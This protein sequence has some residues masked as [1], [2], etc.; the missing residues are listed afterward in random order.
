[1]K[2]TSLF[3]AIIFNVILILIFFYKKTYI[4]FISFINIFIVCNILINSLVIF[5]KNYRSIIFFNYILVLFI[6][7]VFNGYLFYRDNISK[8]NT[9]FNPL[10]ETNINLIQALLA[11]KEREKGRNVWGYYTPSMAL[12]NSSDYI[13]PLSG[14][15]ESEILFCNEDYPVRY[16]SDKYGFNNKN[17]VYNLNN[18]VILLGDSYVN[19]ECVF[20]KNNI[21]GYLNKLN[22]NNINFGISGSSLLIQY[23]IYREYIQNKI[24]YSK[25]LVFISLENDVYEINDEFNSLY[26]K[27]YNDDNFIQNLVNKSDIINS[28]WKEIDSQFINNKISSSQIYNKNNIRRLLYL[29]NL[30][31]YLNIVDTKR[32]FYNRKKFIDKYYI[33]L[34]D[35]FNSSIKNEDIIFFIIPARLELFDLKE[36]DL[37]KKERL[38]FNNILSDLNINY[39]DLYD[40]LYFEDNDKLYHELNNGHRGHFNKNGYE[41]IAN[42]TKK[43][44]ENNN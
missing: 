24:D 38:Y 22:I 25:I 26:N 39:Y 28:F 10:H 13:L 32:N 37:H 5:L 27:Y 42:Y 21:S 19:G 43:L 20:P 18:P 40:L 36:K 15:S 31:V 23:A 6:L 17:S 7:Y 4:N 30:R 1:M 35:K 44:I 14:I 9:L 34:L 16:F 33:P 8:K 11:A 29:T 12:L 3:L 2:K 41:L